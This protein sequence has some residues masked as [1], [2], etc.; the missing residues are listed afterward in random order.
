MKINTSDI[1][2][3]NTYLNKDVWVCD[4]RFNNGIEKP[5]R[6]VKPIKVNVQSAELAKK[7][8]YYSNNALIPYNKKGELNFNQAIGIYDNTGFRSFPGVPLE[9]FDSEEECV[10]RYKWLVRQAINILIKT[11]ENTIQIINDRISTLKTEIDGV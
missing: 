6:K 5:I 7:T 9:I 1:T 2:K 4:L 10:E 8:I 3:N 11:R